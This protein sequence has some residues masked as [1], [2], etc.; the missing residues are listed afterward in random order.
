M[1]RYNIIVFGNEKKVFTRNEKPCTLVYNPLNSTVYQISMDATNDATN[2]KLERSGISFNCEL[3]F[4]YPE[5]VTSLYKNKQKIFKSEDT[6]LG[7][8]VLHM[9]AI[10]ST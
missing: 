6:V 3:L 7:R 8:H 9:T 4:F 1:C 2:D 10:F 5:V